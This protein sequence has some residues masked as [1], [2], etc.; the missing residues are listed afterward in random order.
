MTTI[1]LG[2]C[3]NGCA[4]CADNYHSNFDQEVCGACGQFFPSNEADNEGF[5]SAESCEVGWEEMNAKTFTCQLCGQDG[6]DISTG[7]VVLPWGE[8][9]Q[10]CL[11]LIRKAN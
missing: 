4:T 8:T 9:C 11:N 7:E 10:E 1:H 5:H 2:D 6:K 3:L